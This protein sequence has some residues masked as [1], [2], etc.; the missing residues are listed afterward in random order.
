M[1]KPENTG[2]GLRGVT[3]GTTSICTC[4]IEGKGL[5]YYGYDILELAEHST[6][7]ETAYLLLNGELPEDAQ[8]D[9]FKASLRSKRSLPQQVKEVLERIPAT[10]HP[11]DVMRTGCSMLGVV[12]PEASFEQQMEATERLMA[13]FPSI[14]GYWHR[15][16]AHQERIETATDDDNMAEHLLHLIT[17]KKPSDLHK[18]AMDVSLILY[19]EHEFN[20]STF[21]ARVITGTLS[22]FHSAV[23][24]AIGALRGPLHGGAN[25]QADELIMGCMAGTPAAAAEAIRGKLAR[26]EKIMGFGHAVYKISDPRN[27]V[28]KEWSRKLGENDGDL[29]LFKISAAIEEAMWDE[30]KLFP[31]LDFFSASAYRYMGI[32]TALFTPLFVCSRISGWAAHI[33]EQRQDNKL[34]R[35]NAEYVGPAIRSYPKK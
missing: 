31:N 30:K 13:A 22:D 28:I 32:P 29:K 23:G 34:I 26:K 12:E 7:E 19:A 4:G 25:E 11:M 33:M 3:A 1:N 6:F 18:R 8:L 17:G 9:A 16:V 24:G 27:Q 35:P 14:L 21:T 5:T 2:S 15:W 10:A 20:A